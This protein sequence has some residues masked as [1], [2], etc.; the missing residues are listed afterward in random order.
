MVVWG[1]RTS[2]I[3]TTWRN[4]TISA[5]PKP[6]QLLSNRS[7]TIGEKLTERVDKPPECYCLFCIFKCLCRHGLWVRE[8]LLPRYL[9]KNFPVSTNNAAGPAALLENAHHLPRLTYPLLITTQHFMSTN[10]SATRAAIFELS[11]L[12]NHLENAAIRHPTQN[13]KVKRY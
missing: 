11:V 4:T 2:S 8:R 13:A 5:C 3:N 1:T 10:C 6:N 12:W 9:Q 7:I